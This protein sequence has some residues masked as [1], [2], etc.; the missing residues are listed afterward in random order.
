[1]APMKIEGFHHMQ[2]AMP[3]GEEDKATTFYE[4]ILGIPRVDKPSHLA[5][6]GGCWFE[7]GTVRIHLGVEPEF[8]PA[9]KAHP[10]LVV[11]DIGVARADF[12]ENG[13]AINFDEPLPGFDRF[14]VDDPFGNHIE[15]L[16]PLL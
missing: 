6:R 1:M 3:A 7:S 16:S 11:A 5:A 13:V 9:R 14:Y 2:L 10:A 8:R 4:G 15:F 12:E